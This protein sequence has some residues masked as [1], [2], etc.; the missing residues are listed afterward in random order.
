MGSLAAARALNADLARFGPTVEHGELTSFIAVFSEPTA[1]TE[2]GFNDLLW[3]QLQRMHDLDRGKH[4]WDPTVSSDP[5]DPHFSFSIGGA[6]YFVVG[7]HA[8][9]SRWARRFTWPA[10]VFNPHQQFTDL[11]ESGDYDRMRTLIRGRDTALQGSVNPA[12][13]DYG[14]MSEAG[15]YSGLLVSDDWRCPLHVRNPE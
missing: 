9:S 5:D 10:L 13:R 7:L 12:L 4:A 2:A 3:R 14:V 11:R 8:G 6:A 1:L 15:Q